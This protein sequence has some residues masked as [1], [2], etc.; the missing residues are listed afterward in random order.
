[1]YRAP[2]DGD[3]GTKFELELELIQPQMT[4]KPVLRGIKYSKPTPRTLLMTFGND[5]K[6][7]TMVDPNMCSDT[8]IGESLYLVANAFVF[9]YLLGK[10]TAPLLGGG[11]RARREARRKSERVDLSR[12]WAQSRCCKN[13]V[14][15]TGRPSSSRRRGGHQCPGIGIVTSVG[16]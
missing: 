12:L 10:S 15:H 4:Q 13:Q 8:G 7:S 16:Q 6:H 1:M 5:N 2:Q 3:P 11:R 9:I 14:Y